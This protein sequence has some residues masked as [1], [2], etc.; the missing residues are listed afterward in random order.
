MSRLRS[1]VQHNL[2]ARIAALIVAVIL[3]LYVMNDQNPAMEGTYTIGS[4][5]WRRRSRTDLS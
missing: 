3:W 4:T 5:Q 2:L 1:L